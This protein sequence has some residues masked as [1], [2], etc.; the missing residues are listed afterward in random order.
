MSGFVS[1]RGSR[2]SPP[3][4][5]AGRASRKDKGCAFSTAYP[6]DLLPPNASLGSYC[7]S[8]YH[9]PL[10]IGF[11]GGRR[12]SAAYGGCM[13]FDRD[14]LMRDRLGILAGWRTNG[15]SDDMIAGGLARTAG[16]GIACPPTAV[17]P[18]RL[19]GNITMAQA[20]A[21]LRRQL[22]VLDTYPTAGVR[23][24]NHAMLA[25]YAYASL[26]IFVPLFVILLYLA[27]VTAYA[28]RGVSASAPAAGGFP[29]ISPSGLL[30]YALAGAGG[31]RSLLF[32]MRE[33]EHLC[34]ALGRGRDG[35]GGAPPFEETRKSGWRLLLAFVL[36]NS[37]APFVIGWNF[38]CH[39]ITWSGVRYTKRRGRVFRVEHLR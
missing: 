13:L 29:Q 10:V 23:A 21:H 27:Q 14:A 11:S 39:D 3:R 38:L 30:L 15:Y 5:N 18:Q 2:A 31:A 9:L 20:L 34:H 1:F 32:M 22:F 19:P 4:G 36:V 26:G 17:L 37:A 24:L 12:S 35:A 28:Y 6:H 8:V 33:A 25:L 16:H 7:V